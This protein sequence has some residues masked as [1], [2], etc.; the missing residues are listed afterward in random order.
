MKPKLILGLALVFGGGLLGVTQTQPADAK[1]TTQALLERMATNYSHFSL[2]TVIK[3]RAVRLWGVRT[4]PPPGASGPFVRK[5]HPL[6]AEQTRLL[7]ELCSLDGDR[8]ALAAL[9]KHPDPK[10]R[11]LA[12]GA[13]FQREDGRDLPLI[14]GLIGDPELTFTNLHE[15]MFQ[16]GKPPPLKEVENALTVGQ[17]AR[18]ML[19]YWG[20]PHGGRTGARHLQRPAERYGGCPPGVS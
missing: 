9:L 19:A 15:S 2:E 10:V 12:L 11:T 20:V 6:V 4:E 5:P 7:R 3:N 18:E 17:L 16:G 13:L 8:P 1:D 14:A